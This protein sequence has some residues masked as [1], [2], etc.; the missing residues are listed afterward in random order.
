MK[1]SVTPTTT[2]GGRRWMVSHGRLKQRKRSFFKS[3]SKAEAEASSIREGIKVSGDVWTALPAHDR[4]N[5]I[6]IYTLAKAKGIDLHAAVANGKTHAV[7]ATA[8]K[9][10]DVIDELVSA[11]TKAGRADRYT[12]NLGI[13]L[14]QFAQYRESFDICAISLSDVEKFLD[15]KALASRS[16]LRARLS[17]LFKFC[18]RRGYR[19]DNPCAMLESVTVTKKP[20]QVFT[21]KQFK[22][23]MGALSKPVKPSKHSRLVNYRH[24]LPWFVLTTLCGLRPEEAEKTTKADIHFKEGWIRV[25]AQTTK[26]RQ[27]RIVYPKPE[28]MA[29]LKRVMK[30]GRLP[31]SPEAKKRTIHHLRAALGFD[32]WPKDITRHTAATYWLA[33]GGSAA[34]VSDNLGNSEKVMKSD[35]KALKTRVE[36]KEFW[37]E[38]GLYV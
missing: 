5:L 4:N 20:P 31:L 18:I 29:L 15:S 24:S 14:G 12:D 22:A 36:A 2:T 3:K 35:Y 6:S 32:Q 37:K 7:V 9:L 21:I 16:T 25:E 30:D 19:M 1:V 28:A 10:S 11:K 17:T 23:C 8:H 13:I 33:D 27:R 26:V 34:T 38:V